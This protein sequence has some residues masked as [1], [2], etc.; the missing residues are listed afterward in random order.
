MAERKINVAEPKDFFSWITAAT[1]GYINAN[2]KR[3]PD[4]VSVD[5]AHMLCGLT[6]QLVRLL[7]I[8]RM[9]RP[10]EDMQEIVRDIIKAVAEAAGARVRDMPPDDDEDDEDEPPPPRALQ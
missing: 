1:E 10:P 3:S 4:G 5:V 7:Q 9:K 8:L 6:S 2:A